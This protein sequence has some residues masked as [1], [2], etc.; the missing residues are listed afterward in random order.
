MKKYIFTAEDAEEQQEREYHEDELHEE[1]CSF[2]RE[3][4]VFA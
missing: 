4:A 3:I 2:I 1:P